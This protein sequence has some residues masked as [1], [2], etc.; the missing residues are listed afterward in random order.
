[1][2]KSYTGA[3]KRCLPDEILKQKAEMKYSG[4]LLQRNKD[5]CARGKDAHYIETVLQIGFCL[6]KR[7]LHG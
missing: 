3:T 2:V 4:H 5:L 7:G 1:M 6:G